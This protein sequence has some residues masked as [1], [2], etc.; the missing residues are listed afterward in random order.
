VVKAV[1][2]DRFDEEGAIELTDFFI[3]RR[4]H[5]SESDRWSAQTSS[6]KSSNQGVS[7]KL[8]RIKLNQSLKIAIRQ[9]SMIHSQKEGKRQQ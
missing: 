5:A 7:A 2:F 8:G 1:S 6:S 9:V 4:T 3:D